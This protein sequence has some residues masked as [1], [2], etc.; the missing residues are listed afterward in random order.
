MNFD[1]QRNH[2]ELGGATHVGRYGTR[3]EGPYIIL[4]FLVQEGRI[5]KASWQSN[6]CP[7]SIACAAMTAQLAIGRSVQEAL[8]L[9][10]DDLVV[11]LGGLPPGKGDS[12][13]WAV[14]ALRDA[15]EIKGEN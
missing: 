6:C 7:S 9:E 5:T 13:V 3:G 11:I 1:P 10:P 15:L 4:Y 12:A 14:S 8:R 2:G